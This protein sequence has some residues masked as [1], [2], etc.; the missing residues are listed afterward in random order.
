MITFENCLSNDDHVKLVPYHGNH[1][2]THDQ[3]F[4][5]VPLLENAIQPPDHFQEC[6]A[7]QSFRT[8]F[9]D[10]VKVCS[11]HCFLSVEDGYYL[12]HILTSITLT[13][14]P[15]TG[16]L[17]QVCC[18]TFFLAIIKQISGCIP[19]TASGL[20]YSGLRQVD[21]SK[22]LINKLNTRFHN[23]QQ[24]CKYYS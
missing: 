20:S 24:T 10:Q 7:F 21:L 4:R 9:L 19:I 15:K 11:V 22:T 17:P 5:H 8:K 1:H 2:Q 16:N 3:R 14:I 23:L 6:H 18:W 13:T 12:I